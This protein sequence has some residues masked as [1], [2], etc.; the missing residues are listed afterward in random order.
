MPI[1]IT[2]SYNSLIEKPPFLPF[3]DAGDLFKIQSV[4]IRG[5]GPDLHNSFCAVNRCKKQNL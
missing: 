5:S 4:Q 3:L 1:I 2:I